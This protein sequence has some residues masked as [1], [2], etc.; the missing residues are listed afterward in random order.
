[1]DSTE[2]LTLL[3]DL[4]AFFKGM[5]V[6]WDAFELFPES[7]P[8]A[9]QDRQSQQDLLV[10]VRGRRYLKASS[11]LNVSKF[12]CLRPALP[13]PRLS[14]ISTL[15]NQQCNM[16]NKGIEHTIIRI[17]GCN[18][19]IPARKL[20]VGYRILVGCRTDQSDRTTNFMPLWSGGYGRLLSGAGSDMVDKRWRR[21]V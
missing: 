13:I 3:E 1:M 4:F 11:P 17:I 12:I 9:S 8:A 2:R 14:V 20:L 18:C 5:S 21:K 10:E 6:V 19:T 15:G 7:I 16:Q